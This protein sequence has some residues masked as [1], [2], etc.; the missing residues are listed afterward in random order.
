MRKFT[1]AFAALFIATPA[2]AGDMTPATTSV[3]IY[4]ADE[5]VPLSEQARRNAAHARQ[6]YD[7]IVANGGCNSDFNTFEYAAYCH[8]GAFGN[9]MGSQGD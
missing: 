7:L 3:Y 4:S 5:P 6:T 9:P 2:L 1:I 8:A